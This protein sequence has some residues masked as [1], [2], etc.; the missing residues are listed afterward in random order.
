M[1]FH[2]VLLAGVALAA[3]STAF[4]EQSKDTALNTS[5]ATTVIAAADA[6]GQQQAGAIVPAKSDRVRT[7]VADADNASDGSL[8]DADA[9]TGPESAEAA[10]SQAVANA[11]CNRGALEET[12]SFIICENGALRKAG[13]VEALSA[14]HDPDLSIETVASSYEVAPQ[15]FTGIESTTYGNLVNSERSSQRRAGKHKAQTGLVQIQGTVYEVY[16]LSHGGKT[17]TLF[18]EVEDNEG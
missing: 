1:K 4:T 5:E 9:G 8:A 3:C 10:S 13:V 2:A 14:P 12:R 18:V 7:D 17:G 15:V 16:Q 11:V 6:Q